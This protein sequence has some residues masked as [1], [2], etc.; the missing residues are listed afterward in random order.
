MNAAAQNLRGGVVRSGELRRMGRGKSALFLARFYRNPSSASTSKVDGF[1]KKAREERVF[2]LYP[3]YEAA[4]HRETAISSG[5]W[6][7]TSWP[8]RVTMKV[9]PRKIPKLPSGVIGL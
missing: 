8:S 4:H 2:L 3:S 9:W 5:N 1:R 7:T 6:S